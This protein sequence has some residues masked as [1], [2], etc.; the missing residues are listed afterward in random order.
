[1][2]TRLFSRLQN[3]R[4]FFSR[5]AWS[6]RWLRLPQEVNSVAENG[7]VIVQIDGLGRPH[8]EAAIANGQMP[9]LASLLE[10]ENYRVHSLYSGLPSSTPAVQGEMFYGGKVCRSGFRLSGS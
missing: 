1:M 7:L 3:V 2:I 5:G 9:F 4:R 10:R 8:L 6:V